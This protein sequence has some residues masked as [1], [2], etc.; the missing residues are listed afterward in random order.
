MIG[1]RLFLDTAFIQALL[2][3]RD[4][5]HHKALE[6]L[7]RLKNAKE[8][9]VTEAVLTEVGNALSAVNRVIAVQ[10]IQQCYETKNIYVVSV[11]TPLLQRALQLY[12]DRSDKS[13]GLTDCISFAVMKEQGLTDALTTDKHFVQAGYRALM[14]DN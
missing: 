1:E 2:N 7:P 8:V 13:W 14:L 5:Y 10:F 12:Y 11:D 6:L 3:K 4:Q 9:W